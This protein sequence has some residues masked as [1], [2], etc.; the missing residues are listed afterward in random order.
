MLKTLTIKA[1]FTWAVWSFCL[2]AFLGFV[3]RLAFVVD[4]PEWVSFTNIRHAHSHIALLGWLFAAFVLAIIVAWGF[5]WDTYR[6]YFVWLQLCVLGMAITFPVM[7]YAPI[8]IAFTTSHILISYVVIW[9]F[10]Q[11]ASRSPNIAI[12]R[13]LLRAACFFLVL[14][15]LGTWALGPLSALARGTALYYASIQWYLHFMFNGWLIFALLAVVFKFLENRKYEYSAKNAVRF[16][17]LLL[18]ATCLTFA[19][20]ITWST[21]LDAIFYTNSLGVLVQLAAFYFLFLLYRQV[22]IQV[23]ESLNK[24]EINLVHISFYALTLKVG[25]QLAVVIPFVAKASYTIKNFVIGFIHLL[26]LGSLSIFLIVLMSHLWKTKI[27]VNAFWMMLLGITFTEF[28]LFFQG[29]L[30]WLEKGFMAH[31][32]DY[33]LS[34]S[35]LL[36][37]G[38]FGIAWN[39]TR[40]Q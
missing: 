22:W 11:D 2:A 35:G 21:P 40:K 20:A 16:Y 25:I 33:I 8:S 30:I 19:L 3:L 31:Y 26:M 4:F 29:L 12:S 38:I 27:S 13:R 9:K 23:K 37:L 6:R 36:L 32:Y 5:D 24:F 15:S 10:W 39:F 7:G 18:I 14:S 28:L 17:C 34:A 1:A